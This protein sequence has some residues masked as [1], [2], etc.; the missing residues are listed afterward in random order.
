MLW[1]VN[2][3]GET[4]A[5]LEETEVIEWI[6]SGRLVAGSVV[7]SVGS[8]QWVELTTHQP[9]AQALLE[10]GHPA[11]PPTP[12]HGVGGNSNDKGRREMIEKSRTNCTNCSVP[13]TVLG[14]R[15]YSHWVRQEPIRRGSA[16]IGIE[17]G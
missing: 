15:C 5:P 3:Q 6:R 14:A 12:G 8:Q 10:Q 1:Y 13:L 16:T 17:E 2:V 11:A 9:F 4:L 7:C